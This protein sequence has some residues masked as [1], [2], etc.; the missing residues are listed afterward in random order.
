MSGA[1]GFTVSSQL[2][3]A[4]AVSDISNHSGKANRAKLKHAN[5][6]V[7]TTRSHLNVELDLF[8]REELLEKHYRE[9]IDKHNKNNNSASRRW[10]TMED[11]LA[12]F[13]GRKVMHKGKETKNEEWST[14]CQISYFGNEESWEALRDVLSASGVSEGEILKTYAEA[15]EGYVRAHNEH[16]KTLPIYHSDIH[17]DETTPHGHDAIV[18]MGHT[19]TGKPSHSLNNALAEHYGFPTKPDGKKRPPTFSEKTENMRRYRDDNDGLLFDSMTEHFVELARS[20]GLDIEF[21]AVRT[22]QE[23]SHDYHVYKAVKDRENELDDRELA[24]KTKSKENKAKSSTLRIKELSLT[25]REQELAEQQKQIEEQ[26]F[27]QQIASAEIEKRRLAVEQRE[28]E[29]SKHLK[30]QRKDGFLLTTD[31]YKT[32]EQKGVSNPTEHMD[33]ELME[34]YR[35]VLLD[36]QRKQIRVSR[37]MAVGRAVEILDER[38]NPKAAQQVVERDEGMEL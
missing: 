15:Y 6:E 32:F 35:G 20:K 21:E 22:G 36:A 5:P 7:D 23:T 17:F 33:F 3:S 11:F 25:E 10:D 19:A 1:M 26:R 18:V 2:K 14:S 9:K 29:M 13:E 4:N 30:G 38:R 28:Q 31:I 24:L 8:S 27:A 16:F 12:T 34:T 37:E